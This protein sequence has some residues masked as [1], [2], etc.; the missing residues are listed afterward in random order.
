MGDQQERVPENPA[1]ATVIERSWQP[2]EGKRDPT[3]LPTQP[4]QRS[5]SLLMCRHDVLSGGLKTR[6]S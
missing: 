6:D 4:E 3:G 1:P 2:H 5:P